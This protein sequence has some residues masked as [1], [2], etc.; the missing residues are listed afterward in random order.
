M[1]IF[2]KTKTGKTITVDVERT[3]LVSSVKAKLA[4]SQGIAVA[5]ISLVYAGYACRNFPPLLFVFFFAHISDRKPLEDG[6][7]LADYNIDREA[8]LHLILKEAA[9][10]AKAKVSPWILVA[11]YTL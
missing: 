11:L 7:S 1:L 2:V 5:Q 8:I 6:K 9:P 3:D 4:E 10:A